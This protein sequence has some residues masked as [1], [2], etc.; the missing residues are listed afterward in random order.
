MKKN[1]FTLCCILASLF[2]FSQTNSEEYN[3]YK[4]RGDSLYKIKDYKNS[5]YA[6]TTAVGFASPDIEN[7]IRWNTACSWSLSNLFDSAFAQLD[8]IAASKDL[9]KRLFSVETISAGSRPLTVTNNASAK[10]MSASGK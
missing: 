10:T 3:K 1:L 7:S 8:I 6:Y 2:S 4:E 5:A 9:T